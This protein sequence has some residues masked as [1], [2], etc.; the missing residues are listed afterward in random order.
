MPDVAAEQ[1]GSSF[2]N[3]RTLPTSSSIQSDVDPSTDRLRDKNIPGPKR[4]DDSSRPEVIEEV[5]EPAS[6]DSL[7]SA[8][9]SPS[10][11]ALSEML[12][13]PP[14]AEGEEDDLPEEVAFES[15]G[16]Q[17]VVVGEGI[18]SQP[19]EQTTLLLKRAAYGFDK[20]PKYGSM[21][22]VESQKWPRESPMIKV[23]RTFTHTKMKG[24]RIGRRIISPKSWDKRAVWVQGVRQPAGYIPPVILGLLLNILDALSYGTVIVAL[25]RDV[26]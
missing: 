16:V 8:R 23:R 1:P 11:S 24:A 7:P 19:N 26:M 6:P 5:S 17:P 20:S 10:S 4:S 9:R 12:L 15:K 14:A 21:Q 18:I 2:D 25:L 22:D 3:W 13:K